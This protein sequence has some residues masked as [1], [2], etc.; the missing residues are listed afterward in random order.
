MSRTIVSSN[1]AVVRHGRRETAGIGPRITIRVL[2]ASAAD[3][4]ELAVALRTLARLLVRRHHQKGDCGP[5][6]QR[7]R[8]SFPLT[9]IRNPSPDQVDG[10]P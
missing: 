4:A 6:V 5:N 10:T 9:V 7:E 2:N 1:L 3:P 8:T